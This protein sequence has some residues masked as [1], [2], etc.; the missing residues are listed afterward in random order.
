M[1]LFGI[2]RLLL[3]TQLLL[4]LL[5]ALMSLVHLQKLLFAL[6]LSFDAPLGLV[7][8]TL[9]D[10]RDDAHGVRDVYLVVPNKHSRGFTHVVNLA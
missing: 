9:A 3:L 10:L 6:L 5:L 4:L 2:A 1:V 8:F 7:D